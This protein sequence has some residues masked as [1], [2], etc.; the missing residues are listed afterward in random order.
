MKAGKL[1]VQFEKINKRM[2]GKRVYKK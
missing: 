2:C 1:F